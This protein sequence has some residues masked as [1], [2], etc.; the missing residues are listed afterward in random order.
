MAGLAR[1]S[2]THLPAWQEG[3]DAPSGTVS[4]YPPGS[5]KYKAFIAGRSRKRK[6]GWEQ[7]QNQETQ[8]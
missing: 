7:R 3:Y 1:D 6:V 2:L 8:K 5:M 4:P